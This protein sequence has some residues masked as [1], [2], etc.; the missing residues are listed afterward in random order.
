MGTEAWIRA[1]GACR[2][3]RKLRF[4]THSSLT[5][6]PLTQLLGLGVRICRL[7]RRRHPVLWRQH[8][9][10]QPV[11]W[12]HGDAVHHT[13]H[14]VYVTSACLVT[15][16]F[17][18]TPQ[19]SGCIVVAIAM[20]I[21]RAMKVE[22]VAPDEPLAAYYFLWSRHTRVSCWCPQLHLP[23]SH[24]CRRLLWCRCH[25]RRWSGRL[26]PSHPQGVQWNRACIQRD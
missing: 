17:T 9:R 12:L 15:F 23:L 26:C 4:S 3:N 21:I 14:G 11:Y 13:G 10:G 6:C 1:S 25:A 2:V 7:Y 19:M 20:P 22:P 16:V 24:S 18:S 5:H 8:E